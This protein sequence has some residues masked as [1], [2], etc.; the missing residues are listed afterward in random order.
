MYWIQAFD[1]PLESPDPVISGSICAGIIIIM[2]I[3]F[4]YT[5]IKARI[6]E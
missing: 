2:G 1:L 3:L 5:V 4:V 6:F